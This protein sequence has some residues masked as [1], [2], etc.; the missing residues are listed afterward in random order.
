MI[1]VGLAGCVDEDNPDVP[2]WA[3]PGYVVP[4]PDF[5]FDTAIEE[6][7]DHSDPLRHTG[8]YGLELVG[9]DPLIPLRSDIA[10]GGNTE[11]SIADDDEGRTWA[12]IGNFG[13]HRAFSIVDVTD[14]ATPEYA[15]EFVARDPLSPT[16]IGGGSFWD[17]AAFPDSNLVVSSAQAVAVADLQGIATGA[18]P[19]DLGGGI[20]LVN[21]SDKSAPFAESF[22]QVIDQDALIPVGIHNARPFWAAEAWYVAATTA[23]G[24]TILYQVVGEPGSRTL[25]E[26]SRVLGIHDTT[27]QVHP[28]TGQTLLYGASGGVHITDITDPA[29][30]ELISSVPNGPELSAYHII[31]PSDVLIEDR[32]YI[33]S[34]TEVTTD[35]PPFWTVLDTTDPADPV[36]VSTWV[37]PFDEDLYL[38]G[39]Y[40]WATHNL[41]FDHGRI[42]LGHYHAGVWVI[43]V[44]SRANAEAPV[45]LAYYQ[46]HSAPIALPRTPTGTDIPAVWGAVRHTDG[47]VYAGDANGGL[48]ILRP[49]GLPS[50]LEN[51]PVHPHNQR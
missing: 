35:A 42:Y 16:R 12:F 31:V 14:P 5:D 38:P 21:T 3:V 2:E 11:V 28:L 43:D 19:G 48:F 40:R 37:T 33:V 18:S 25:Q 9:W 6:V 20:Y 36:I 22:T 46:P 41:D 26:V 13:P 17:V 23:N 27:V 15:G 30:P 1:A 4:A 8:A 39:A 24:N 45:T 7:H 47:L 49:T 29:N 44:S 10:A 51:E 32:H 34:A 50:P